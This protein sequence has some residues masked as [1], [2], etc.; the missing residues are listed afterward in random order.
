MAGAGAGLRVPTHSLNFPL[1]QRSECPAYLP[2]CHRGQS[3]RQ[4]GAQS[5]IKKWGQTITL[6]I[7]GAPVD[8]IN[9]SFYLPRPASPP[10]PPPSGC[11]ASLSLLGAAAS[12][13]LAVHAFCR[14]P[15]A[16]AS[17][18]GAGSPPLLCAPHVAHVGF[19][20]PGVPRSTFLV[21]LRGN[22]I[23]RH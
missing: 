5:N 15:G 8:A 6:T 22:V 3:G 17:S 19:S 12:S 16:P 14:A 21:C 13:A 11:P 9:I 4:M 2:V 10:S 1:C 7:S 23:V 20:L 18:S